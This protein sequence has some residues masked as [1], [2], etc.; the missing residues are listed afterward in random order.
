MERVHSGICELGQLGKFGST[1]STDGSLTWL[2][3]SEWRT[4]ASENLTI[5]GRSAANWTLAEFLLTSTVGE[6]MHVRF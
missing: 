5:L 4:Y 1:Y 3:D 2:I 6:D